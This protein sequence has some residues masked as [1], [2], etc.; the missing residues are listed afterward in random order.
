MIPIAA[1]WPWIFV[2]WDTTTPQ[3][4]NFANAYRIH[5]IPAQNCNTDLRWLH[6][7]C[8][9]LPRPG[10][11]IATLVGL[12]NSIHVNWCP[13]SM[14]FVSRGDCA[15]QWN[16]GDAHRYFHTNPDGST[17]L[18]FTFC[19]IGGYG[20]HPDLSDNAAADWW[21]SLQSHLYDSGA[22]GSKSD[23]SNGFLDSGGLQDSGFEIHNI[24]FLLQAKTQYERCLQHTN[25]RPALM[26]RSGWASHRFPFVWSSDQYTGDDN[27]M[28]YQMKATIN[29]GLSGQPYWANDISGIAHPQLTGNRLA[30]WA[31]FGLM[32]GGIPN[33]MSARPW[34]YGATAEGVW[35]EYA[36]L[37]SQFMPYL[38]TYA[39]EASQT[40]VPIARAMVLEYQDDANGYSMWD[41]WLFGSEI[42]VAP[43]T[44]GQSTA[45]DIYLPAG[46]WIDWWDGTKYVGPQ[47]IRSYH[48]PIEKMPMFVKAGAV[49]PL[50]PRKAYW[51]ALVTNP[52][53]LDIYPLGDSSFLLYEDDGESLDYLAGEYA[54]TLVECH[55]IDGVE[56]AI[57]VGAPTG[58]FPVAGREYFLQVHA[59]STPSQITRD[60]VILTEHASWS[61]LENASEGWFYD[62]AIKGGICYCK[63]GGQTAWGFTVRVTY[64]KV[65]AVPDDRPAIWRARDGAQSAD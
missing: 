22:Y 34:D 20:S 11:D 64:R 59:S 27:D 14:P 36:Y 48:A 38:Y 43:I 26:L 65:I 45:R 9:F 15:P 58:S 32:T 5:D 35:R 42:L 50:G 63:P 3:I 28:R 51:D 25:R 39:Y 61:E 57:E 62:D 41:Q 4:Y 44:D 16:E 30:R 18:T 23:D 13:W 47:T 52:L 17:H 55:H 33:A 53:T 19:W 56:T 10:I 1:F 12:L 24:Y 21:F 6:G 2:L 60:G 49:I 37:R 54:K 31:E 46:E 7:I 40:G 8:D 29:I